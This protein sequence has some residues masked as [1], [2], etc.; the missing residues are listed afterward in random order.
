MYTNRVVLSMLSGPVV[1]HGAYLCM[2]LRS[3]KPVLRK[4]DLSFYCSMYSNIQ[5]CQRLGVVSMG[6]SLAEAYL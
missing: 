5:L 3:V 6:L 4:H 1:G 2:C